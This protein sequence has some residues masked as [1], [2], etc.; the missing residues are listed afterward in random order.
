M[1]SAAAW[2]LACLPAGS[3]EPAP[4]GPSLYGTFCASCHEHP[5]D[6]IPSRE[7]IAKRTPDEV[8][9]ALS[10]G[11][12]RTQAAGLNVNDRMALAAYITGRAP[13][14][15]ASVAAG[16]EKN[17]CALRPPASATGP[18]W[19]GWGR[20]LQNSRFQ[21][22]PGLTAAALPQLMVLWAFAYHGPYVYGQ[23]TVVG[24][25]VYVTSSSGRIYSLDA[26]SGCTYWTF[27]APAPSRTAVSVVRMPGTAGRLAAVFGD[28]SAT[29]YAIDA[30]TG[31]LIWKKRLDTHPDA[32]I[33]G[34]P[35]FHAGTL[36]VPVSS[37]EELSAPV[38]TY[39]C[40]KFRGSVAALDAAD[41]SVI[42]QTYTLDQAA[43]PYRMSDQGTQLYGPAGAA[44]WSAPTLDPA[45]GLLYIGTGNSYTDVPTAHTDSIM[46]LELRTGAIRWVNQ[47]HEDDNFVVGCDSSAGKGNCPKAAGPDVDFGVSPILH[48]MPDGQQ[49]LLTGQKSGQVYGLA[50]ETGRVL[51]TTRVSPGS[52]LGGVE[53]GPAA[54][55]RQMY[56]AVSDIYADTGKPGGLSAVR[57]TDGAVVWQAAPPPSVCSWGKRSCAGAQSQA[58]T[59]IPG[60]VLSGSQ[61]GHLRAYDSENGRVIWDFDTGGS[62]VTV[63]GIPGTGGSL[64]HGGVTVAGG[65][66]FVNSGYGH[67]NGQPGN[68]LLA[69][70]RKPGTASAAGGPR[71]ERISP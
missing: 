62:F 63:N 60:A 26:H 30:S 27:D 56:V 46:A 43:K 40:C 71:S 69:F 7:T 58:V 8:M 9:Q 15:T 68:V 23:P 48:S 57:I 54:D 67:I 39:E 20:D 3:V 38:P 21:P 5:T 45:R 33:T 47:L 35:V 51:W 41:G 36:Y 1:L 4:D 61:D 32:R 34:A 6:R 28:D 59:V 31:A 16:P 50:P 64:D 44:V 65:M 70:G 11:A 12:M 42:W 19:N 22:D 66:L 18:A 10:S 25:R 13:S 55:G 52:S 24:G 29:V 2:L 17:L 14:S 49:I 37:L 53:W